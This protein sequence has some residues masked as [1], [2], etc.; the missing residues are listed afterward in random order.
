MA[1]SPDRLSLPL[2]AANACSRSL[3]LRRAGN[4]RR[5]FIGE[6][7]MVGIYATALA[8]LSSLVFASPA[9]AA[10]GNPARGERV[11]G[12]CTACHSLRPNQNMTGPSLADLWNRKAGR[13]PFDRYS[14]ALKSS[15]VV[16]NDKTL[17]QW[18]TDPQQVVPAIR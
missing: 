17:D 1:S 3:T 7:I 4:L 18:I 11:F 15:G 12:A 9:F 5:S 13:L 8:V 16:W 10:E 6:A 2:G 14:D